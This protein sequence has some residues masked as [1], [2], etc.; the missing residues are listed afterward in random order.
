[1]LRDKYFEKDKALR[2]IER[3]LDELQP[4]K[5]APRSRWY[6]M[7]HQGGASKYML[8][9]PLE[10]P[11]FAGWDVSAGLTADALRR[12]DAMDLLA[13]IGVLGIDKPGFIREVKYIKLTRQVDYKWSMTET[14][15]CNRWNQ[16][17][18]LPYWLKHLFNRQITEAQY[19]KLGYLQKYFDVYTRQQSWGGELKEI[20]LNGRFPTYTLVLK[21]KKSYNTYIGHLYGDEIGEYEKLHEKLWNEHY[22]TKSHNSKRW[23]KFDHKR[24]RRASKMYAKALSNCGY[25]IFDHFYLKEYGT[26]IEDYELE[27]KNKFKVYHHKKN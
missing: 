1:M 13:I 14:L 2:R 27:C 15:W 5:Y 7:Y 3:R 6:N 8:W 20:Y 4:Y 21:A 25:D 17:A 26:T 10:K 19:N 16:Y 9:L 23:R 11:I 24:N 12:R 18:Q 22:W